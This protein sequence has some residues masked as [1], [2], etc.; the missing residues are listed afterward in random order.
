MKTARR[1]SVHPAGPWDFPAP[2]STSLDNGL[3]TLV[4]DLPGQHVLSV[5]LAVP[6]PL[7]GEP[8]E[9]EGIGKVLVDRMR[10]EEG[11]L[12]PLYGPL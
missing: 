9:L 3:R 4:Y 8:R 11:N 10:N 5:R 2:R 7:A 6:M 12:Y 1:P